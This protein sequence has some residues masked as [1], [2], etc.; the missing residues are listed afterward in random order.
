[1]KYI[2]NS[3]N[4]ILLVIT[5]NKKIQHIILKVIEINIII[6]IFSIFKEYLYLN[7]VNYFFINY[8]QFSIIITKKII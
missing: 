6:S 2:I 1:M 8:I 3:R 7:I 4:F 5:R